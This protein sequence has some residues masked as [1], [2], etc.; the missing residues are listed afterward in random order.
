MMAWIY[1]SFETREEEI[2]YH[3]QQLEAMR[4]KPRPID[5]MERINDDVTRKYHEVGINLCE[6]EQYGYLQETSDAFLEYM[7]AQGYFIC[8]IDH[9]P[10]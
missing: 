1:G 10:E 4:F 2:E 7:E 8:S 5:F 6:D 9:Y 3:R